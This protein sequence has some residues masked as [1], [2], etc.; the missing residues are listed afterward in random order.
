VTVPEVGI[1]VIGKAHCG[2]S[3]VNQAAD[4]LERWPD[5]PWD[6]D[7]ATAARVQAVCEARER[8][9]AQERWVAVDELG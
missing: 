6:P 5:G 8:A 9:A 2:V 4:Q 1:G 7:L 3:V